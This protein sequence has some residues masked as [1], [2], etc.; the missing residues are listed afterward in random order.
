[1]KITIVFDGGRTVELETKTSSVVDE[2]WEPQS[3]LFVSKEG[4]EQVQLGYVVPN[5][6]IRD[7]VTAI[8]KALKKNVDVL[9]SMLKT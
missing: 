8:S 4:G 9:D 7:Q 1:M 6:E 2:R 3:V 5:M